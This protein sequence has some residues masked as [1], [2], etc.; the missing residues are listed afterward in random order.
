MDLPS[1][2][3]INIAYTGDNCHREQAALNHLRQVIPAA[4][5]AGLI[6][7]W[8]FI[9]KGSWRIRYMTT[10]NPDSPALAHQLISHNVAWTHD[11]YEPEIRAFGGPDAM[12]AA[13]TLFHHDSRHL[14]DYLDQ[15]R[16]DRR[17]QSLILCTA[18][19][20]AAALDL[21]EQ[22]DVWA[23]VLDYRTDDLHEPPAPDAE[24]WESFTKDVRR[25][26]EGT[27]SSPGE[28]HTAFHEA[29][30]TLRSLREHGKLTRGLRAVIALHIIFH[31]NRIGLPATTQARLACAAAEAIFDDAPDLSTRWLRTSVTA[32][33]HTPA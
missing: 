28:W 6:T 12:T 15:H 5:R 24:T 3:Q 16:A 23:K 10:D 31:W 22:G 30:T 11:I 17:E 19:M 1:W 29:G 20:R 4:E 9:R 18:L 8:W 26:I 14:L 7:S 33:P 2:H 32:V 25:L 21:N 27:A 13:H